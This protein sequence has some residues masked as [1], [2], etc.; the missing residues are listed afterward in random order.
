MKLEAPSRL[1]DVQR[2]TLLAL[3]LLG[4][5]YFLFFAWPNSLGA[6]TEGMLSVTSQDETITYPYVVRM[7]TPAHDLR[8]FVNR[9]IIYGDYHYGYPFYFL[10]SLVVLP[11]VWARGA[12]F[13][14]LPSSTCSCCASSS[15]CSP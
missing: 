4:L 11:V 15:R 7:V 8:E 1:S 2:R 3:V 9:W 12:L 13:T 6:R 10:S 14:N 5:A